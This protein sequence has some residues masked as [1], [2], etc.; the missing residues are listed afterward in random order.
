MTTKCRLKANFEST[1]GER[2]DSAWSEYFFVTDRVNITIVEDLEAK[3]GEDVVILGQVK[4]NSG[5][6]LSNGEVKITY[7][8]KEAKVDVVSGKFEY[9]IHLEDHAEAETISILVVVNDKYGNYGDKILK[10]NVLPIPTRIENRFEDRVLTPGNIFRAR[11]ILY[12][13]NSRIIPGSIINIMVFDPDEKLVAE[14]DI[15]SSDYFEFKTIKTQIP[16][17]YFLLSTFQEIKEQSSFSIEVV[18]RITM[19]QEGNFV[20]V[21]NV[22]NVEYEDEVTIILESDDETYL[23]SRKI[24]LGAGEE[25]TIDLSK[26]VPRGTYDVTLPE[27]VVVEDVV[28]DDN[29]NIVKKSA[30]G[31]SSIVGAVVGVAGYLASKPLLAS[32]IL[33]LIILGT[34]TRYSW[35]FI[36]NRVKG[37]E[38]E[39]TDHIFDDFKY[40]QNEDNKPGDEENCS[41]KIFPQRR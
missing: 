38:E 15:H 24:D 4:K 30:E 27:E 1:N 29:R 10:L 34:V 2:I 31:M 22:G 26:E 11:A 23:I 39:D 35:G 37:K 5:E 41:R 33:V 28:I 36:K 3:P 32:V 6:I 21:E 8:D 16:G 7:K 17:S 13:H 20:Y 18:R 19:K 14:G 40:E 12:D 9:T 25:V